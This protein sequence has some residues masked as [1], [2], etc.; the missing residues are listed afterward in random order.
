M[1]IP[2]GQKKKNNKKPGW[3]SGLNLLRHPYEKTVYFDQGFLVRM[4]KKQSSIISTGQEHNPHALSTYS[5]SLSVS[6]SLFQDLCPQKSKASMF[7]TPCIFTASQSTEVN[8]SGILHDLTRGQPVINDSMA[9]FIPML[10][11]YPSSQFNKTHRR[12]ACL[13]GLSMSAH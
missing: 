6:V 11:V 12:R 7:P 13:A 2:C 1:S 9:K 10:Q 8:T 5:L 3:D 4:A